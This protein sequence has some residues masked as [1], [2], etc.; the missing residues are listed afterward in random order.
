MFVQA[1][2]AR[3]LS[4]PALSVIGPVPVYVKPAGAAAALA[5][6]FVVA[7]PELAVG[8][9]LPSL[10]QPAATIANKA[11]IRDKLAVVLSVFF[12]YEPSLNV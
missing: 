1:F 7:A 2:V 12:I 6:G 9:E 5:S 3:I 11:V 10:V 8:S 4:E